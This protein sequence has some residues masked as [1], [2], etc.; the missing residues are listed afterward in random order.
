MRLAVE[1][2][3]MWSY[4]TLEQERT[5]ALDHRKGER[6]QQRPIFDQIVHQERGMMNGVPYVALIL[7][8]WDEACSGIRPSELLDTL[9]KWTSDAASTLR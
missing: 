8:V 3:R 5:I 7:D 1:S 9:S 4:P 2:S 6:L